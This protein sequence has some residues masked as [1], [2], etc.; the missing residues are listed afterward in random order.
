MD[1]ASIQAHFNYNLANSVV[2]NWPFPHL[3][4]ENVFPDDFYEEMVSSIHEFENHKPIAEVLGVSRPDGTPAYPERVVTLFNN[5][6]KSVN[7]CW[8]IVKNIMQSKTTCLGLL[9]KFSDIA[10]QRLKKNPNFSAE[11]MLLID[12]SNYSIGPHTDAPQKLAAILIYLPTTDDKPYLGTSIYIPKHA[13]I[14]CPGGP[15]HNVHDFIRVY[16]APYK[17]NTAFAFIKTDSSFHGVEKVA[18]NDER[19]LIQLFVKEA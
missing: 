13:G 18:V 5:E 2:R 14:T 8:A 7:E 17:P 1:E 10:A 19:H 3:Y 11:S 4:F 15:H 16:T 12:K 6:E 9:S